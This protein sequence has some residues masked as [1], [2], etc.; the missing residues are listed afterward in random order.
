MI[1]STYNTSLS[2]LSHQPEAKVIGIGQSA[3]DSTAD[4]YKESASS[5]NNAMVIRNV[6]WDLKGSGIA[7]NQQTGNTDYSNYYCSNVPSIS[8]RSAGK[9][10]LG[11]YSYSYKNGSEEYNEGISFNTRPTSLKGY[12]KYANDSQDTSEKGEA[13]FNALEKKAIEYANWYL[14]LSDRRF[15]YSVD[16]CIRQMNI[17]ELIWRNYSKMANEKQENGQ[18]LMGKKAE[19]YAKKAAEMENTLNSLYMKLQSK[20]SQAGISLQ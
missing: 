3:Y 9:L 19:A 10:F 8:N 17:L 1:P 12:Y 20:A 11:S 15:S 13:I 2:W 16:E 4:I 14:G 18:P 5:G 6:A 7:D